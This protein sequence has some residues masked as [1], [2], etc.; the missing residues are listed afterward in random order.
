MWYLYQ[1]IIKKVSV[2]VN[3]TELSVTKI[4]L[5]TIFDNLEN[6]TYYGNTLA[7]TFPRKQN[8]LKLIPC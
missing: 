8:K 6:G 5:E 7:H 1:T 2:T 4:V 3:P